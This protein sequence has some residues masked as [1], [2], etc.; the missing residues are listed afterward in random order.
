M[1][2]KQ[3]NTTQSH[4]GF[5][6]SS[7]L[8]FEFHFICACDSFTLDACRILQRK[9]FVGINVLH[10]S[11]NSGTDLPAL[12]P[13][14]FPFVPS[15]VFHKNSQSQNFLFTVIIS[16]GRS[17]TSPFF[18]KIIFAVIFFRRATAFCPGGRRAD[19]QQIR[20][21]VTAPL[22]R[23]IPFSVS[24]HAMFNQPLTPAFSTAVLNST[25]AFSPSFIISQFILSAGL[26]KTK[27]PGKIALIRSWPAS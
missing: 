19:F 21:I 17:V 13:A 18:D 25:S 9:F 5:P 4:S 7:T 6:K 1:Q 11:K 16:L 2:K 3:K 27:E 10:S 22:S 20:S 15:S 8:S 23:I 24:K 14:P 12:L 26:N